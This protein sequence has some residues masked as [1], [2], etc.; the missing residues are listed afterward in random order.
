MLPD[1]FDYSR[2]T[3]DEILN[4]A[5]DESSLTDEGKAALGAEL[6]R[7]KITT[8]DIQMY[9]A[10][11]RALEEAPNRELQKLLAPMPYGNKKFLGRSNLSCDASSG[12]EEYDATLWLAVFFFPWIPLGTYRLRRDRSREHW[13]DLFD[14]DIEVLEK[15]PLNWEQIARTWLV[16]LCIVFAAILVFP[17]ILPSL[18]R[19]R[20]LNHRN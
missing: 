14:P 12:C 1:L 4:L 8:N 13:W 18:N 7:R 9:A 17:R 16:A 19:L 6:S 10:E 2:F 3:D 11:T 5:R 15:L 20:R